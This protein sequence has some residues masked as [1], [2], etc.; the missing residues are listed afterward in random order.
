MTIQLDIRFLS[1]IETL[2]PNL[3]LLVH[4]IDDKSRLYDQAG[5]R[6]QNIFVM[7]NLHYV[8]QR[9]DAWSELVDLEEERGMTSRTWQRRR[10]RRLKG[11]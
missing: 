11:S 9:R 1:W 3:R 7:N 10:M 6:L 5:A 8:V 4:K 2:P